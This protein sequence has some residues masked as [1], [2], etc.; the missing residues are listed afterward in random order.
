MRTCSDLRCWRRQNSGRSISRSR[1]RRASSGLPL[2][3]GRETSSDSLKHIV[4]DLILRTFTI[5]ADPTRLLRLALIT[6]A[7]ASKERE[8]PLVPVAIVRLARCRRLGRNVDEDR[9]VGERQQALD[10]PEPFGVQ[11]LCLPVGNA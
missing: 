7:H 4:S 2:A 6:L 8:I 9:H 11:T 5:D 3:R 10:V 1:A